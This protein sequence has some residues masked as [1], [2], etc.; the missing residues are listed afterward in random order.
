MLWR[1]QFGRKWRLWEL[2]ALTIH[3]FQLFVSWISFCNI[4]WLSVCICFF[5]LYPISKLCCSHLIVFLC[6]SIKN[7]FSKL[8]L[9]FSLHWRLCEVDSREKLHKFIRIVDDTLFDDIPPTNCAWR[10][11]WELIFLLPNVKQCASHLD[12]RVICLRS[13]LFFHLSASCLILF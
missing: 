11:K 7:N 13:S 1:M 12:L 4:F 10:C 8:F 3:R 6:L 5:H 2:D 9:V